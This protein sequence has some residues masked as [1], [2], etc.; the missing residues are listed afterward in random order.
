MEP[1]CHTGIVREA[2]PEAVKVLI[3]QISACDAC[4]ARKF[5]TSADVREKI[6]EARTGGQ[7]FA[8]GDKVVLTARGSM[9]LKAVW[10]AYVLPLLLMMAVL[11][12]VAGLMTGK[13]WVAA[14]SAIVVLAVYYV[15]LSLLRNRIRKNFAFEVRSASDGDFDKD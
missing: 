8:V 5:C 6:I 14:V 13:E 3:E 12:V 9:G 10:V 7:N 4:R 15:L 2:S 11:F 1:V